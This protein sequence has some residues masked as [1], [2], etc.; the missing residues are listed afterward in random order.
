MKNVFILVLGLFVSNAQADVIN[1]FTAEYDVTKWALTTP[2]NSSATFSQDQTTLT[3]KSN[4]NGS[5]LA[6]TDTIISTGAHTNGIVSFDWS[7]STGD[8]PM[9][10]YFG[11][12]LNDDFT[13]LSDISINALEAQNGSAFFQVNTGDIFGFRTVSA[14]SIFGASTTEISNFTFTEVPEP[15]VIAFF[16]LAC[17]FIYSS[18]K[19]KKSL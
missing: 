1:A 10:D 19:N 18:R 15:S 12:L 2:G 8:A 11:W 3:Q 4:D 17:G 16:A 7:Y 14:D 5:G 9:W 13:L 6:V